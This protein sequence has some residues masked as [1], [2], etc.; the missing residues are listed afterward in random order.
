[1]PISPQEGNGC[2]TSMCLLFKKK[3]LPNEKIVLFRTV[4]QGGRSISNGRTQITKY[5][6]CDGLYKILC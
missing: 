4:V 5:Y 2:L 6:V 1:M 3:T